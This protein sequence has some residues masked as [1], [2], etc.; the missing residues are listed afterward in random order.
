M[1]KSAMPHPVFPPADNIRIALVGQGNFPIPSTEYAPVESHIASLAEA[2]RAAGAD[3]HVVNRV[4]PR[5]K[6]RL[7]AHA[8]WVAREIRRLAP[9]VIHCHSPINAW[10]LRRLGLAPIVF[11][12][13]SREWS[14]VG[15]KRSKEF[16]NHVRGVRAAHAT[17]VLSPHVRDAVQN[18][19]ALAGAQIHVVP[20]GVDLAVFAPPSARSGRRLLGLGVVARVKRWHLVAQAVQGTPWS[21][22]LVG[23]VNHPDYAAEL[24]TMPQ[25]ELLGPTDRSGILAALAR[26]RVLAHPSS[27]EAMSLAVLEGMSAGLPVLGASILRDVVAPGV[28]GVL[29]DA[30]AEETMVEH[31]RQAL[32]ETPLESWDGMGKAA[33][34]K[35]EREYSWHRIAQETLRVYAAVAGKR[36][37]AHP[38]E[39]SGPRP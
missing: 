39:A 35:V 13:H 20:N 21:L 15:M 28:E 12:S 6:F 18:V 23:P 17:I 11:T 16:R 36:P 33:R 32:L 24:R 8:L 31:F 25:V 3:V 27:A 7:L 2:L 9:D 30:S 14:R 1:A 37:G 10:V 34:R 38:H 19:P 22:E 29:V 5:F 4:L 26:A